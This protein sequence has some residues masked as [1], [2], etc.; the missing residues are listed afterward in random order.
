[1][2]TMILWV[3]MIDGKPDLPD[4]VSVLEESTIVPGAAYCAVEIDERHWSRYRSGINCV[5]KT[6]DKDTNPFDRMP[7]PD[8]DAEVVA[9]ATP[10]QV[11]EMVK[12]RGAY[13]TVCAFAAA[14]RKSEGHVTAPGGRRIGIIGGG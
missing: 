13:D 14:K 4:D 7:P 10:E 6:Y 1:M 9:R 12:K 2:G 5:G 8:D 11:T 3:K